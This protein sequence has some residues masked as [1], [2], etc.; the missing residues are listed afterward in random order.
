MLR[1]ADLQETLSARISNSLFL[2]AATTPVF[3][4]AA[5]QR[6]DVTATDA[7]RERRWRGSGQGKVGSGVG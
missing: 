3:D 4:G 5:T 1:L 6:A 7:S 2:L